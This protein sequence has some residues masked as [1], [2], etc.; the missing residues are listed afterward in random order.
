MASEPRNDTVDMTQL[1]W[2]NWSVLTEGG[3]VISFNRTNITH[4][5]QSS[6]Y[7]ISTVIN[8][9][10]ML[11]CLCGLVGNGIVIWLLG[12][13]MKRNAYGVYI[14]NLAIA[15]FTYILAGVLQIIALLTN[16]INYLFKFANLLSLSSYSVGLSLLMAI[17]IERCLSVLW[18]IWY[19]CHRPAHLSTVLCV[20]I[21][22]L[23]VSFSVVKFVCEYLAVKNVYIMRRL[24]DT[25]SLLTFPVLI[26]SS[27]ILLLRFQS[28]SRRRQSTKLYITILLN[29]LAFLLL[30]VPRGIYVTCI[31][32][33]SYD[34]N[35][36]SFLILLCVVNSTVNP[37]I[38]FFVGQYGK[39]QGWKS[40]RE[41]LQSALTDDESVIDQRRGNS[42][43]R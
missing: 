33:T 1:L 25:L 12:F 4:T 40:L 17:N 13:C 9:V 8:N 24:Y 29:V 39:E 21:W 19:K 38:Y 36:W 27:G 16:S 35:I 23:F 20:L 11:I 26:V 43:P 31:W 37:F 30:N 14:L 15:D 6:D 10:I 3:N 41:V 18:P 5:L 28:F 2:N 32:T 7:S 34:L 22:G 42:I